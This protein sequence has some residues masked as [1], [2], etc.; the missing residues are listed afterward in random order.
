M[1]R[2]IEQKIEDLAEINKGF[3]KK[4]YFSQLLNVFYRGEDLIK[5]N[6][7]SERYGL[8]VDE[9]IKEFKSNIESDG[10]IDLN[11]EA[12]IDHH[13][14]YS[15]FGDDGDY[16]RNEI[17]QDILELANEKV[18]VGLSINETNVVELL[19]KLNKIYNDKENDEMLGN[20]NVSSHL[21]DIYVPT[22]L[23]IAYLAKSEEELRELNK[24]ALEVDL[25]GADVLGSP[26]GLLNNSIMSNSAYSEASDVI[27]SVI[28]KE[29][30]NPDVLNDLIASQNKTDTS[31]SLV[32]RD[33]VS[34]FSSGR[35]SFD[36]SKIN[37][38]KENIEVFIDD[39][40]SRVA[41]GRDEEEVF[42]F[43]NLLKKMGV[44]DNEEFSKDLFEVIKNKKEGIL[45]KNEDQYELFAI[46]TIQKKISELSENKNKKV[47]TPRPKL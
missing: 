12:K 39:Q 42:L 43:P 2:E 20:E 31:Y 23:Q 33:L 26:R 46:D 44:L 45:A 40:V 38:K 1:S 24:K 25:I 37:Y 21:D 41:Y 27:K 8:N 9:I 6:L 29:A 22:L 19:S 14:Y 5:E 28:F 7:P 30:Q 15:D 34:E 17:L 3:I 35:L 47:S 13:R 16:F 11:F 10:S 32:V 36:S 4:E 18:N